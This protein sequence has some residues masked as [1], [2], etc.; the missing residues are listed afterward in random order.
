MTTFL[1]DVAMVLL[2]AACG[3]GMQYA[4]YNLR[5]TRRR[6]LFGALGGMIGTVFGAM[7]TV[8]RAGPLADPAV[9]WTVF[10]TFMAFYLLSNPAALWAIFHDNRRGDA[11]LRFVLGLAFSFIYI[12]FGA[13]LA[14]TFWR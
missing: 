11:F 6:V 14:R 1:I 4:L 3:A 8:G 5:N 13:E 12:W 9:R 7:V 10:A 2:A